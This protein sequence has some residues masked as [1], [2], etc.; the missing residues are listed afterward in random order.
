MAVDPVGDARR[1]VGEVIAGNAHLTDDPEVM[2]ASLRSVVEAGSFGLWQRDPGGRPA[3][4]AVDAFAVLETYAEADLSAAFVLSQHPMFVETV[5]GGGSAELADDVAPLISGREPSA[6]AFSDIRRGVSPRVSYRGQD[7]VLDGGVSRVSGIRWATWLQVGAIDRNGPED[8]VV[9]A[10][11]ELTPAN[12]QKI[13]LGPR[14]EAA[15]LTGADTRPALF[16]DLRVP[17]THV[18]GR[19]PHLK[20][21]VVD[22]CRI[23]NSKPFLYGYGR[24]LITLLRAAG[25]AAVADPLEQRLEHNRAEALDLQCAAGLDRVGERLRLRLE[26]FGILRRLATAYEEVHAHRPQSLP[27]SA[28]LVTRTVRI[29]E[30][31]ATNRFIQE[32]ARRFFAGEMSG[33]LD[34][35]PFDPQALLRMARTTSAGRP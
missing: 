4:S 1:A 33:P 20:W 3:A 22:N 28:D 32:Q 26:G 10:F 34:F 9:F 29:L 16:D 19:Q 27:W 2:A 18:V 15:G 14:E 35:P 7:L 11:V 5:L 23:A 8:E 17:L 12:R 25:A 13:V 21:L 30:F 24:R 31:P 6:V